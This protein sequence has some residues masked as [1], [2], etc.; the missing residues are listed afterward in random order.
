MDPETGDVN[1]DGVL[2]IGDISALIDLLIAG[3]DL[4]EWADV[5]GDGRVTIG[6]VSALIDMLMEGN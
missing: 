6:D 2:S 5:N 4:P 3:G 1:G